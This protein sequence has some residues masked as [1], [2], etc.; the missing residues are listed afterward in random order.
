MKESNYNLQWGEKWINRNQP[1][2]DIDVEFSIRTIKYNYNYISYVQRKGIMNSIRNTKTDINIHTAKVIK[3][4]KIYNEKH[5]VKNL[6][7]ET[8]F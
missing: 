6:K 2:T 4:V 3:I 8:N 5:Y 1:R 7:T